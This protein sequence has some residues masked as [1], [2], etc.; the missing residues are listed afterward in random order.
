MTV[1]AGR[2]LLLP[3]A[4]TI[5]LL[6]LLAA[7]VLTPLFPRAAGSLSRWVQSALPDPGWYLGGPRHHDSRG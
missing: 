1:R 3:L 6:F 2:L 4:G 5:E 7:W